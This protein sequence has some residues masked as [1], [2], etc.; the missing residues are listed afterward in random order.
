MG[1]EVK[2]LVRGFAPGRK[3]VAAGGAAVAAGAAKKA[4]VQVPAGFLKAGQIQ[5]SIRLESEAAALVRIARTAI[6]HGAKAVDITKSGLDREALK[7]VSRYEAYYD[8]AGAAYTK[9]IGRST[10]ADQALKIAREA[11]EASTHASLYSY[12][13]YVSHGKNEI[14]AAGIAG[15]KAAIEKAQFRDEA[16]AIMEAARKHDFRHWS[17][18]LGD[19]SHEAWKKGETLPERGWWARTAAAIA[20]WF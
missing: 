11:M 4:A 6:D 8:A 12:N 3:V 10:T 20:R 5:H 9:A 7:V 13:G 17:S 19:L 15:F 18:K 16:R 2:A 14:E 1:T